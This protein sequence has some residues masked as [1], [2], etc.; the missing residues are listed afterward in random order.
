MQIVDTVGLEVSQK[1]DK[2]HVFAPTSVV[3][4]SDNTHVLSAAADASAAVNE[5]KQN[6]V[7][8]PE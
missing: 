7:N 5:V 1:M 3:F 2:Q 4:S 8:L 6:S